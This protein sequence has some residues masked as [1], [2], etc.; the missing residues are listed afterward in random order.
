MENVP[1]FLGWMFD[2]RNFVSLHDYD[3]AKNSSFQG[4]CFIK[5]KT[6]ILILRF[7]TK[8]STGYI[9]SLTQNESQWKVSI[10]AMVKKQVSKEGG[11]GI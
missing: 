8:K 5:R 10:T 7:G 1:Q 2:S 3:L 11:F 9:P 6:L 4:F